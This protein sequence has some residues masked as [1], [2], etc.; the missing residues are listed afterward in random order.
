MVRIISCFRV[1]NTG[2]PTQYIITRSDLPRGFLAAQV[3]HA[4]GSCGKHPPETHVVV[5]A[6]N[7]EPELRRAAQRLDSAGVGYQPIQEPDAPWNG[8]LTALGCVLVND[9]TAVRKVVSDIPLLK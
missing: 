1:I 7:S 8:Q 6:V 9:R 3:A 4:A 5:L 2:C